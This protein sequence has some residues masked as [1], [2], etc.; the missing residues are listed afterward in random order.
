MVPTR[1]PFCCK[2]ASWSVTRTVRPSASLESSARSASTTLSTPAGPGWIKRTFSSWLPF[3]LSTRNL[4]PSGQVIVL[5]CCTRAAANGLPSEQATQAIPAQTNATH[6]A[7]DLIAPLTPYPI[8]PPITK[9]LK[10]VGK[11]LDYLRAI[12]ESRP[13]SHRRDSQ[14]AVQPRADENKSPT[15]KVQ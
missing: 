6:C 12:L 3:L 4:R 5:P 7:T 8:L 10:I 14:A 1:L 11:P 2:T 13:P 9:L 15:Q